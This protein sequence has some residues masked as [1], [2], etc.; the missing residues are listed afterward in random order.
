MGATGPPHFTRRYA[1]Y[2]VRM[3][4]ADPI[5]TVQVKL[6]NLCTTLTSTSTNY[7]DNTAVGKQM[8]SVARVN[9][10]MTTPLMNN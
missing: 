6:C 7:L 4:F 1:L 8:L 3:R 10:N 2:Y 9:G 5:A